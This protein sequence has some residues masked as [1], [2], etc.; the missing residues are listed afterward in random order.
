MR[1]EAN[2]PAPRLTAPTYPGGSCGT[3]ENWLR[4]DG[5]LWERPPEFTRLS[6]P[7]PSVLTLDGDKK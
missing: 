6:A 3:P 1:G 2:D 4:G 5:A 7:R